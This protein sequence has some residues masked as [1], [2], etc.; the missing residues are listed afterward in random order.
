MRILGEYLLKCNENNKLLCN[1]K[2]Y[3]NMLNIQLFS[4]VKCGLDMFFF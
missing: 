3:K 1:Q 4:K 2:I